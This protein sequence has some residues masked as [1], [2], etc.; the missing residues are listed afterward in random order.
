MAALEG[1]YQNLA[2]LD[3]IIAFA[4]PATDE[5]RTAWESL[6]DENKSA[7][8]RLATS[9][10]DALK[11]IGFSVSVSQEFL[12]PRQYAYG[13]CIADDASWSLSTVLEDW[14]VSD[15]PKGLRLAHA[16]QSARNAA[17]SLGF[18]RARCDADD[19]H[20]GVTSR[21][22]ANESVSRDLARATHPIANVDPDARRHL[23]RWLRAGGTVR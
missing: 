6:S 14:S 3:A 10:L 13:S 7:C 11:Y 15:L 12:W 20:A 21:S 17:R 16:L 22:G 18:D 9:D 1:S 8:A 4:L 2:E 5:R 19:A 23:A